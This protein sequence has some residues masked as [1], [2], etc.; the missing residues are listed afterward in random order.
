MSLFSMNDKGDGNKYAVIPDVKGLED[1]QKQLEDG[2][3]QLK[4]SQKQLENKH[5]GDVQAMQELLEEMNA[6]AV[7]DIKWSSADLTQA[8]FL[9]ANGAE[10][11][12]ATYPDL[13]AVYEAMGFPW[14]A[15]DGSTTFNLPNL[16]GKFPEGADSAGGYHEAGLPNIEGSFGRC[17]KSGTTNGAFRRVSDTTNANVGSSGSY[18]S[19]ITMDASRCSPIYGSST[20][21]QPPSALLIPYVKAFAGASA[22]STDLAITEVANDVARISK[23]VDE[24]VY[25]VESAV[26]SDG[27]W[28]RKYSDGWLEQGGNLTINASSQQWQSTPSVITFLKP[29][30]I[31]N[32]SLTWSDY[33]PNTSSLSHGVKIA[34][35]ST[36]ATLTF[37]NIEKSSLNSGTNFDWYACGMG[38]S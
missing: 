37:F 28:Y 12:R 24:R 33:A 10:V 4:D 9:I 8:G 17:V 36:N 11:G 29:F 23:K 25:L 32:Y 7:G 5:D 6:F 14:G 21:V 20:T 30:G 16:I 35:T 1:G 22:D 19:S 34:K 27:S 2:Q 13:C 31:D 26:N 38:A 3:K 18:N 15:G